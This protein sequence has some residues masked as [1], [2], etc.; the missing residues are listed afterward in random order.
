MAVVS[1][2][3][4]SVTD[5]SYI[6]NGTFYARAYF[7]VSSTTSDTEILFQLQNCVAVNSRTEGF[8]LNKKTVIAEGLCYGSDNYIRTN[9]AISATTASGDDLWRFLVIDIPIQ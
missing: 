4:T 8:I 2:K 7:K 6:M 1:N 5:N 9:S 3:V